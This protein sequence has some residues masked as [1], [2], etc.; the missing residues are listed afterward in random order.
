MFNKITDIFNENCEANFEKVAL[1]VFRYQ[2]INN[3]VYKS[4]AFSFIKNMDEVDSLSK[5]PFLPIE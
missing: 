3:L 2:Y 4:W 1:E 5:I